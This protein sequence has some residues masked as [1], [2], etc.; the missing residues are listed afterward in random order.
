MMT[1]VYYMYNN[2]RILFVFPFLCKFGIPNE[3]QITISVHNVP[4]LQQQTEVFW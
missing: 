1:R 3:A 4:S 2:T